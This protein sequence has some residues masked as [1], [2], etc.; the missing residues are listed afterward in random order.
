MTRG[1]INVLLLGSLLA[2][3][4]T[5]GVRRGEERELFSQGFKTY[6]KLALHNGLQN[7]SRSEIFSFCQALGRIMK[8]VV[9]L[10]FISCVVLDPT[11][12]KAFIRK[13]NIYV[14]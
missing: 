10:L 9:L 4:G 6:G 14:D 8:I 1:H 5:T 11:Q 13:Y 3:I 2:T 12:A 7:F